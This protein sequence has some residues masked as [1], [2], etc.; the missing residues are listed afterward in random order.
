MGPGPGPSISI[1]PTTVVRVF[2]LLTLLRGED[3]G[4]APPPPGTLPAPSPD[5]QCRAPK[6]GPA[7]S[8]LDDVFMAKRAILACT[9]C[10]SRGRTGGRGRGRGGGPVTPHRAPTDLQSDEPLHVLHEAKGFGAFYC[11]SPEPS[12]ANLYPLLAL[13]SRCAKS[14]PI[15]TRA[16]KFI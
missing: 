15:T 13:S 5:A 16:P 1:A 10:G 3:P 11:F 7:F 2:R 9:G 6:Y 14:N 8:L 4:T 12:A